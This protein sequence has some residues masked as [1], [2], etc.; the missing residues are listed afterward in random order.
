MYFKNLFR[1]SKIVSKP[2]KEVTRVLNPLFRLGVIFGVVSLLFFTIKTVSA[3]SFILEDFESFTAP[4]QSVLTLD[5]WLDPYN[6]NDFS[7][8]MTQVYGGLYSMYGYSASNLFMFPVPITTDGS[9][10]FQFYPATNLSSTFYALFWDNNDTVWVDNFNQNNFTPY[11]WSEVEVRFDF[12]E[13]PTGV[14]IDYYINDVWKFGD[15][16]SNL[17]LEGFYFSPG[18]KASF[19]DNLRIDVPG[20]DFS[21]SI[22]ITSPNSGTY[23]E[24]VFDIV[25]NYDTKA[26]DW[27]KIAI[28]FE[29]WDVLS[30]CPVYGTPEFQ[31]EEDLGYFHFGTP[32]YWSDVLTP[33]TGNFSIPITGLVSGDYNCIKCYFFNS[34]L[35]LFSDEKCTGYSLFVSGVTDPDVPVYVIPFSD[36][37]DYYY[38]NSD[39]FPVPT[40]IFNEMADTI[41]PIIDKLGGAIIYVKDYFDSDEAV[42]RGTELGQ[43]IPKARGYLIMIDNFVNLPLSGFI[44]FYF[45]TFAVVISYKV[46]SKIISLLKP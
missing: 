6:N 1:R 7:S 27:D 15:H 20:L 34:T 25:G 22:N 26:E 45:L 21:A 24:A 13:T 11:T 31:I 33:P 40:S 37:F 35:Q 9:F 5:G 17:E 41:S 44:S 39:Q 14:Q 23:Q 29:E 30:T 8:S 18:L 10:F 38:L 36:W 3:G 2:L 46:I 28:W 32:T 4:G 16:V 42:S 43:A 19:I 12:D